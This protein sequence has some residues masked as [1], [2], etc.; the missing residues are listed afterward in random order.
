MANVYQLTCTVCGKQSYKYTTPNLQGSGW[1]KTG[2]G[3][4]ICPAC[5]KYG[6]PLVRTR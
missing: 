3:K 2:K 5:R 4:G 6:T 1:R